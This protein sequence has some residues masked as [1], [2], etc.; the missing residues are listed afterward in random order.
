MLLYCVL[1]LCQRSHS[2]SKL[3]CF[4][5]SWF[6]FRL[7]LIIRLNIGWPGLRS[8]LWNVEEATFTILSLKNDVSVTSD[9]YKSVLFLFAK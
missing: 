8:H 2:C 5:H 1:C 9:F 3:K 4:T 6:T 7:S